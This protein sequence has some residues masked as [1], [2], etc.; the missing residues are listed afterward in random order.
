MLNCSFA[1]KNICSFSYI[2]LISS[3]NLGIPPR[4]RPHKKKRPE[5]IVSLTRP[6]FGK[7]S[8]ES[9]EVRDEYL[10]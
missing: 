3:D 6:R 8:S 4:K 5:V 7:R 2:I 9:P 1:V 10:K